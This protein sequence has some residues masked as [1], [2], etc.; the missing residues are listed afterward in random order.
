MQETAFVCLEEGN[1]SSY[2]AFME[3]FPMTNHHSGMFFGSIHRQ[4]DPIRH[5]VGSFPPIQN[6]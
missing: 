3:A 4:P 6:T 5:L 1:I 2:A